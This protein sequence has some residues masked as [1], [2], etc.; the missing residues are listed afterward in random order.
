MRNFVFMI[1]RKTFSNYVPSSS[2]FLM[3]FKYP[4]QPLTA[5]YYGESESKAA[6]AYHDTKKLSEKTTKHQLSCQKLT[7][8]A[9]M[10]NVLLA[11]GSVTPPSFASFW[12]LERESLSRLFQE[13]T[14]TLLG[15]TQVR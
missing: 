8:I 15:R 7:S 9:V 1:T 3:I 4:E 6:L 13:P 11:M 10:T 5:F 2:I 12:T 14:F